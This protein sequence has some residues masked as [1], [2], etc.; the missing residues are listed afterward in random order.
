[1]NDPLHLRKTAESSRT[2][3][4]PKGTININQLPNQ[5]SFGAKTVP[6]YVVLHTDNRDEVVVSEDL[7][8]E[9][10]IPH[11]GSTH[12][13]QA[14]DS[15]HLGPLVGIFTA[16]FTDHTLRPIGE[17]TLFFAKLLSVQNDVGA[18]YFVFGAHHINWQNGTIKGFFYLNDGW[19][20][21][22][23]PIPHV[24]YDRIPNRRT[25]KLK[26]LREVK[27]R[28][29]RDYLIPWFNPGF[30]DKWEMHKMLQNNDTVSHYLP[31]T[32]LNPTVETVEQMLEKYRHVY[33]KPA[34]GSLGLGIHQVL[35][36]NDDDGCYCRFH[37]GEENRL[38]RYSSLKALMEKQFPND[39]LK[40]IL[41]QQGIH[42]IRWQ[43]RAVDFRIHTN[44]NEK[45][46]WEVGAIAAKTA[47]S[48]SVTTHIRYGGNVKTVAE[49]LG[50]GPNKRKTETQLKEASLAISQAIDRKV[51]GTVGEIGFD[52][53]LDNEGHIWLFEA[54]AK[55]GRS[56]FT[57]PKLQYYDE[58]SRKLPL[59]FAVHLAHESITEPSA[60][61]IP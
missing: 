22:N 41:V 20:Q 10:Q 21:M 52:L 5:L 40:H 36:L 31:E 14:D 17:R 19:K 58:Q 37:N 48:G 8:N 32:Y 12:L 28:L 29:Q 47:G 4:V 56:I 16:G 45:G 26:Q 53:G 23:V 60:L 51:D 30:F 1:M 42:L 13:F 6:C 18:Y 46:V 61:F 35:K 34:K 7:W 9:L 50:I 49:V 3:F 2:I 11:G 33:F 44:K 54:N 27:T 39:Q 38:R 25:E 24:V 57:H 43:K 15:L 55:P 59:A